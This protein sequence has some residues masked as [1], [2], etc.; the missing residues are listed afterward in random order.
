MK[1][2]L[3]QK[4]GFWNCTGAGAHG[5]G[6]SASSAY[7]RWLLHLER[8]RRRS[9]RTPPRRPRRLPTAAPTGVSVR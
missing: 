1:P 4:D 2:R 7:A 8:N 5:W 6:R 3:T 9:W